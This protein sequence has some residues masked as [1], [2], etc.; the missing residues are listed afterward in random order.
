MLAGALGVA[1]LAFEAAGLRVNT[2]DSFPDTLYRIVPGD[3]RRGDLVLACPTPGAA[4]AEARDRGYLRY[5]LR[6]PAW[7]APLIKRVVAVA[8]D[9]VHVS[10]SGVSVNGRPLPGS[11]PLDRD[12]AGRPLA[13]HHSAAALPAGRFW[14][15]SPNPRSY[16]S[17][18]FGPLPS[19]AILARVTPIL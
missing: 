9:A 17:R 2:S 19:T 15:S 18:Y 10:A 4:S 14:L 13:P 16:D 1:A 11:A 3:A 12:A 7:H 8:G 6:C 5:G